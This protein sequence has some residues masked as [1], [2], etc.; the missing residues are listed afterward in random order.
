M[1]F[2]SENR[3]HVFHK[4]GEVELRHQRERSRHLHRVFREALRKTDLR[5]RSFLSVQAFYVADRLSQD[6]RRRTANTVHR[7]SE[8]QFHQPQRDSD[9]DLI[10]TI[11][12]PYE[13]SYE[14]WIEPD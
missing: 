8:S 2:V 3:G 14:R 4:L 11:D 12:W 6:R 13:P 5:S 7:Q 9:S 1:S 10:S